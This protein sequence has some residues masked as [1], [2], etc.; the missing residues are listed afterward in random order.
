MD[1]AISMF[2]IFLSQQFDIWLAAAFCGKKMIGGCRPF[3]REKGTAPSKHECDFELFEFVGPF[4]RSRLEYFGH[5]HLATFCFLSQ[6]KLWRI[7]FVLSEFVQWLLSEFFSP[8]QRFRHSRGELSGLVA[9]WP[10][11]LVARELGGASGLWSLCTLRR[12]GKWP[13][14]R[15]KFSEGSLWTSAK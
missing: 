9:Q 15:A 4:T 12:W 8:W 1:L 13:M 11:G 3:Y 10:C 6:T 7:W 5:G 2:R 14:F